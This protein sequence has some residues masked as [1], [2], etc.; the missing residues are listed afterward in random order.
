ML[1]VLL[2]YTNILNLYYFVAVGDQRCGLLIV[3][4]NIHEQTNQALEDIK[5]SFGKHFGFHVQIYSKLLSTGLHHL[6]SIVANS[7]HTNQDCIAVIIFSRGKKGKYVYDAD[8]EKIKTAEIIK[9]FDCMPC[10]SIPKFLFFET[11]TSKS[12]TE[13][14]EVQI[15]SIDNMLTYTV[16]YPGVQPEVTFIQ[17][18]PR[19]ILS[20]DSSIAIQDCI[21]ITK[22]KLKPQPM[23]CA[24]MLYTHSC[25]QRTNFLRYVQYNTA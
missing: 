25:K 7:D 3:I 23:I 1:S 18:L 20:S 8:G 21:A 10:Q 5:Q 12:L 19:T 16:I 11:T 6:L 22:Q 2:V 14:Y 24:E 4:D 17:Q 15:N 13:Q 9:H